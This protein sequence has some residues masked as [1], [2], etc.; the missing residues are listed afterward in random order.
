MF[1]AERSPPN[2]PKAPPIDSNLAVP[3]GLLDVNPR[4]SFNVC[5]LKEI[6]QR[7]RKNE[8]LFKCI[9]KLSF[10]SGNAS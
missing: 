6:E 9:L 5:E 4:T 1:I 7:N 10:T 8:I 3:L 2:A